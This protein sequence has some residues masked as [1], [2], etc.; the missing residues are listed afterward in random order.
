MSAEPGQLLAELDAMTTEMHR[1]PAIVQPSAYWESLNEANLDM[2]SRDGFENFKRT[3]NRNY[4]SWVPR[5]PLNE[6][7]QVVAKDWI[8]RRGGPRPLG[9]RL[10]RTGDIDFIPRAL[11]RR[12]HAVFLALLWEYVSA[13]DTRGL[14]RGA[15]EP[16]LGNPLTVSYGGRRVSQDLCNSAHEILSMLEGLGPEGRPQRVI[17]LGGGYG[18]VAWLMLN[19]FPAVR[20]ILVDIPPALA[21]AQ[22]YLTT[23]YPDKRAFRFRSFD[24][25]DAV[26]D[27]LNEAD[28]AFLTPNQ[29]DL[30]RS[31]QADLFVNISSLHEMRRDQI[32]HYLLAVDRHCLV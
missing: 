30:L 6:H 19:A 27:E 26:A 1:A 14:L 12:T 5:S 15:N 25:G 18:R 7:F 20:Y 13:R 23:L 8:K 17:E 28:M 9:A 11:Q 10:A 32:R 21:L 29:L 24:D 22:R 3:I 16:G 4:F 31:L 2:L